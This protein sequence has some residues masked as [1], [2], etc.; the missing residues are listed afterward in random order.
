MEST[1]RRIAFGKDDQHLFKSIRRK[2]SSRKGRRYMIQT[3]QRFTDGYLYYKGRKLIGITIW[4]TAEGW[5]NMAA[6]NPGKQPDYMDLFLYY[7]PTKLDCML[8]D[9]EEQCRINNL[10]YIT[11]NLFE[12]EEYPLF[13]KYDYYMTHGSM[14]DIYVTVTKYIYTETHLHKKLAVLNT[15]VG[16]YIQISQNRIFRHLIETYHASILET[17]KISSDQG[18]A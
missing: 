2:L 14:A 6:N 9:L 10:E 4:E 11:H 18:S 3:F 5:P 8:S 12:E 17:T 15:M 13:L 7:N 16:Y 1:I